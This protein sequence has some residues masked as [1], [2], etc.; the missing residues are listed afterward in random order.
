MLLQCRDKA[1]TLAEEG[2]AKIFQCRNIITTLKKHHVN[3]ATVQLNVATSK[4]APIV[5]L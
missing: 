1:T 4:A 3:V 2:K 5:K